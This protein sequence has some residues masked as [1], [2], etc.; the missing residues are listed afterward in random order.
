MLCSVTFERVK[1][2]LIHEGT[3]RA[4]SA[5][6]THKLCLVL[7]R[8]SLLSKFK[9]HQTLNFWDLNLCNLNLPSTIK[10]VVTRYLLSHHIPRKSF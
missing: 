1:G 10:E 3:R 2:I 6:L 4:L 8:V 5:L 9:K 7:F